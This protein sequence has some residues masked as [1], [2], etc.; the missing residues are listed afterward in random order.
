MV[1]V[2]GAIVVV[3]VVGVVVIVAGGGQNLDLQRPLTG[4]ES[5]MVSRGN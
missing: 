5:P 2:V 3:V 4:D 1:V